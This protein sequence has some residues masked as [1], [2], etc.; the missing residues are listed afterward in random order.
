MAMTIR[1]SLQKQLIVFL[2]VAIMLPISISIIVTYQFTKASVKESFLRDNTTLLYQGSTNILNYLNRLNQTSLLIYQD[3]RNEKSFHSI[4]EKPEI[5][6]ADE[7]E[8]YVSVQ[9][10][11][12][13]LAEVKQIHMY[14]ER[15][16]LSYR[17]SYNL[18]RFDQ[19]RSYIPAF[20][21]GKDVYLEPTHR[22]HD[23]GI[24]RFPYEFHEDVVT[25]HRKILNEPTD[26]I[27]GALSIDIR[28]DALREICDMLY[29]AG[30]EQ[31]YLVDRSGAVVYASEPAGAGETALWLSDIL[32][33][34]E[35]TGHLEHTDDSFRGIHLYSTLETPFSEW[36]LVKRVPYDR[37]YADARQ[38]TLING[39]IVFAFLIIAAVA[40]LFVSFRY[41]TPIKRLIR[42]INKV[43][44]GQ[45]DA[46][47]VT[48][49]TDEIGVLSRR[50]YQLIQRLN[51]S[52]MKEYRLELANKTNQLKAL[53]AQVNPHFMNNAL[54]SIGTLA[55]QKNEKKIY[56][57]IS[58]LGK[59]MRYQM[60][61]NGAPVPFAQEVDYVKA[62]L[63]LQS[64]RFEEQLRFSLEVDE[65]AKRIEVPRMILQ[66]VVENCFKHGFVQSHAG[67]IRIV[68]KV[69]ADGDNY[70]FVVRVEDNGAGMTAERLI[71]LQSRLNQID[72]LNDWS[73]ANRIGLSNVL[74]RLRLFFNQGVY[75]TLEAGTPQ[76]LTV[77]IAIPLPASPTSESEGEDV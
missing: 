18:P 75:L 74:S 69:D 50:F 7:K 71:A 46:E 65:E 17:F 53:Q 41:T 14:M 19:G 13:S 16:D 76:G 27:L 66:P 28:L 57:L 77:E 5:T 42:Y 1:N 43:E 44:A 52:I 22:S 58:S 40:A 10:M 2:M 24:A 29:E 51:Q 20:E 68:A 45:L 63:D 73:G 25:L 60:N 8:L 6:F 11:V 38:L 64:Q 55:L 30:D 61:T 31:L 37:L 36:I 39:S 4:V 56:S 9:F 32:S 21:E 62:Y 48:R 47:L 23:F 72:L 12:N 49:R 34:P 3:P 35:P 70:R 54:Q 26:Q 33:R 67:D 59:M 15:S